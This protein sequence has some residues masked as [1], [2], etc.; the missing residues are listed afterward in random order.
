MNAVR[1]VRAR[2]SGSRWSQQNR[3]IAVTRPIRSTTAA[4]AH[5]RHHL[6]DL[7]ELGL[8]HPVRVDR[9]Q[10]DAD[11]LRDEAAEAVDERV[12]GELAQP[13]ARAGHARVTHLSRGPVR[14]LSPVTAP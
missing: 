5:E 6:L 14:G 2:A 7:A 10:E 8:A 9:Q 13:P 1:I 12:P 3:N 11:E 4:T